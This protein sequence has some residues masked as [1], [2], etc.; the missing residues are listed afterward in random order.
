MSDSPRSPG[1][2]RSAASH[3]AILESTVELLAEGGFNRLTMGGIAE[4]AGAGK[5]TIYRRWS[6][7]EEVVLAAVEEFVTTLTPPDTGAL[8]SDLIALLEKTARRYQ[9]PTGQ[10]VLGLAAELLH[11]ESLARTFREEVLRPRRAAVRTLLERGARR[12]ELRADVDLELVIDLL[13]GPL[14]YRLL[15]T[16]YDTSETF[17]AELVDA[18]LL[19][20]APTA[21]EH[22]SDP[23]GASDSADAS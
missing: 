1:R 23:G 13:Y 14:N 5:S 12:G 22:T 2:P 8:R 10:A 11:N 7:K 3:R 16:G 9:S 19:G 17:V 21:P 20:C 6:S 15:V 18:V 4:R